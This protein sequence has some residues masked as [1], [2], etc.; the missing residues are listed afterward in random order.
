MISW[1]EYQNKTDFKSKVLIPLH[2]EGMIEFDKELNMIFLSPKGSKK[3]EEIF[4]EKKLLPINQIQIISI[5][6][7]LSPYSLFPTPVKVR[8]FVVE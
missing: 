4:L 6:F 1:V 5:E 7:L 8:G 2:R 3:V